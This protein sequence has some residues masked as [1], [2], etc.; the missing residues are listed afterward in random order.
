MLVRYL[1]RAWVYFRMGYSTYLSFLLGYGSTLVTVYYL[2]IKNMPGL[3]DIFPQFVPFA[4]LATAIGAPL[5]VI[6]GWVHLKRS[7]LYSAERDIGVEA[8]PYNYKLPGGYWKEV[9][10]PLY[11]EL[12]TQHKRLLDSQKSITNQERVQIESLEHKL[13]TLIEGGFVGT[14]RRGKI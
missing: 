11:L 5:A 7:E 1:T 14:P 3:L 10:A 12:L 4:V 2:A 6:V 8:S 9:L 13:Q